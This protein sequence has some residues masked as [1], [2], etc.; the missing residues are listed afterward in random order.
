MIKFIPALIISLLAILQGNA[1]PEARWTHAMCYDTHNKS[2][3]MF[4][5][6]GT[7][8]FYGDLWSFSKGQWKKLADTGP[9]P[10]NKFAFAYD[11]KRKRAVLF[12]GSGNGDELFGDTW[13]WTGSIWRKIDVAGPSARDHPVAAFDPQSNTIILKGGFNSSGL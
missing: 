8:G 9:T 13:E 3:L 1:Q 12:G 11:E 4:G 7:I 10:R 2:V 6:S 5:G